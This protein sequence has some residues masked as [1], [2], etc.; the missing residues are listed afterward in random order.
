MLK[1]E[2]ARISLLV[3]AI[4]GVTTLALAL[5]TGTSEA[6][7]PGGNPGGAGRGGYGPGDGSQ[8]VPVRATYLILP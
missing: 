1:K 2:I 7:G 3:V 8:G 5:S 4:F 6:Q